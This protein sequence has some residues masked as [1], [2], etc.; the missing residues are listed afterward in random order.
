MDLETRAK[1][2]LPFRNF[3]N[4]KRI[5]LQNYWSLISPNQ[6]PKTQK[7]EPNEGKCLNLKHKA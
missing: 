3:K 1:L 6:I 5:T 7:Q 4:L 2:E